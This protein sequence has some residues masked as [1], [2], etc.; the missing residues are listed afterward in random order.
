M[1]LIGAEIR[2]QIVQD[3]EVE[4]EMFGNICFEVVD[5][6]E[7]PVLIAVLMVKD[8]QL[9]TRTTGIDGVLRIVIDDVES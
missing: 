4:C 2:I 3:D 6:D 1:F 7:V 5:D 9:R 8:Q